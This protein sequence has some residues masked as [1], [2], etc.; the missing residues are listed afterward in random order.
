MRLLALLVCCLVPARGAAQTW[1][2][3]AAVALV[4]R[5]VARRTAVQGDS[6]LRSWHVRAHGTLLFLAQ[7]GDGALGTPHLV[8]ADELD[9]EVY[10]SAPGRSKQVIRGWRDRRYLPT[11]IRYHRDHL[12]IVTDG[13]GPTIRV[14]EGDEVRDVVHP[15]SPAGLGWYDFAL[16]DS[17]QVAAGGTTTTLDV[18]DVRPRAPGSAGVIGTLYLDRGSAELVRARLSFTPVSYRDHSVEDLT[19]LLDY[20]FIDGRA[21]LPWKQ[22]IEIR[23]NGG[24]VDLPY[25][26]VIRATWEFGEYDLDLDLP[27]A[28]FAGPA[29]DGLPQ[30]GD[31]A[32][33]W[34]APFD[35]VLARAGPVVSEQDVAAARVEVTRAV[36]GHLA[37]GLAPVRVSAPSVSDL[38]HFDRV[39]GVAVG[40]G[41]R[42][43]GRG[44]RVA[45]VPHIGVGTADGRLTGGVEI[46]SSGP[47]SRVPRFEVF[48]DR[49]VRDFSDLPVIS[50]ALNSLT[51]QESGDDHGDYVLLEGAGVGAEL[52][53]PG[54]LRFDVRLGWED[55]GPLRIAASPSRGGFRPQPDLGG[56]GYWAGAIGLGRGAEGAGGWTLRLDG[57]TGQTAWGR[58]TLQ[59]QG[60]MRV[61]ATELRLRGYGG[62]TTDLA[63]PWRT[64]VLGGR[65]T[66]LGDDY[67][68]W[69]GR[70][71]GWGSVEWRIPIPVLAIPLGDF[72]STGHLATVAP[73]VAG[74]W[75]GGSVPGMP[76]HSTGPT[77][78]SAGVALEL[79]YQLVRIEAGRS[80]QT[81]K[82][83]VTFDV[84]RGWWGVL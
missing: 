55:P 2:D 46:R 34:P 29:I 8:K 47:A 19:I 59:G 38:V 5:A 15:L 3:T 62:V 68:A 71:M 65:G 30:A 58:A 1:N 74:G 82:V 66:L 67:R 43:A 28:T 78:A 14:G 17:A 40:F 52:P 36:E 54:D 70:R 12:G 32:R 25:T 6:G 23:R 51:A 9:V 26:G 18:I 56:A 31:S 83:G 10:W 45:L 24:W 64:F 60:G 33:P 35:S 76:W 50:R 79:F 41:M 77:R 20:A 21:W 37:N 49:S 57:G 13:Y 48:A 44:S 16:R 61:G 80:F 27:P 73:F 11:D 42:L 39:E 4:T 22:T 63:P 81:G 75:T 84:S 69:G 72:A 7:L 53:L